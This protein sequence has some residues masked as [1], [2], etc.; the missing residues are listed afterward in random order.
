MTARAARDFR[1]L[2]TFKLTSS[3]KYLTIHQ[4]I[5][6]RMLGGFV[7]IA[8]TAVTYAGPVTVDLAAFQKGVNKLQRSVANSAAA[9]DSI[10]TAARGSSA[11]LRSSY[12][13]FSKELNELEAQITTLRAQAT[14][15]RAHADDHY[16]AWQTELTK[17]GNPQ[18]RE[19]A[20]NRF[21]DAKEEFDAIITVADEAKRELVPFMADLRDIANY[22]KVDLSP[23]AVKSLNNNIWKLGNKARS[24]RGSLE[25]VSKQI[26]KALEAQPQT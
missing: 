2:K 6:K 16:K 23:D 5:V 13:T 24:V 15:M 14:D 4:N 22:F 12:N 25:D 9:L 1:Y 18:L 17:M 8:L 10:R 26:G 11:D 21:A 3:M 20:Q 7:A 19:K